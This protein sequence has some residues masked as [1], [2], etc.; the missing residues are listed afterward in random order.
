[1]AMTNK[2]KREM[3]EAMS[4]LTPAEAGFILACITGEGFDE[5][6][7]RLEEEKV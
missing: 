2:E 5:A 7:A 3:I 6:E 4:R 1:M